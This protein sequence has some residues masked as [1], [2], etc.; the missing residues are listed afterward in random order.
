MHEPKWK[1]LKWL[2]AVLIGHMNYYGVPGN[3]KSVSL[4]RDELVKRW[5]KMLRRRSQRHTITW[6]KFGPWIRRE[7]PKVR[8]VHAYPEMR[9]RA[10]YSK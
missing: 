5:F 4:F 8:V 3:S 10:R 6:E 2:K 7:L 9:F 1:T